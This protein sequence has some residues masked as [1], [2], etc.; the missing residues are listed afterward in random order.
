MSRATVSVVMRSPAPRGIVPK[1]RFV[2]VIAVLLGVTVP[3]ALITIFG[4][5]ERDERQLIHELRDPN[6]AMRAHAA[7]ELSRDQHPTESAIAALTGL[8]SDSDDEPRSEAVAAL[9]SIGQRDSAKAN[10][11]IRAM[12]SMISQPSAPSSSRVEAA[13]VLSQLG[14]Q[15]QAVR[16]VLLAALH[17]RDDSLRTTAAAALG[18]IGLGDDATVRAL[19]QAANDG[20][21]DVRAAGLESLARLRP[22]DGTPR[23]AARLIRDASVEVRLAAVY[24]LAGADRYE[25]PIDV[26]IDVAL[27]DSIP[28]IRRAAVMA[29]GRLAPNAT[30][31]RDKLEL[32][33]ADSAASVRR[34][35]L[36]ALR[37]TRSS[38]P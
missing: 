5:A 27:R 38:R 14:A 21:P 23:V 1:R 30:S 25:D 32:L 24:A 18:Q 6:A 15:S 26:A 13:R 2:T 28:E 8:L 37:A 31:A 34:A 22:G 9:I 3:L 11:V 35:A 16:D 12:I 10:T 20:I 29:L 7:F 19:E 33:S 4:H 17:A 36:E